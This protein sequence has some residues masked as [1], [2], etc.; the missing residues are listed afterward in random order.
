MLWLCDEHSRS[1]S[2]LRVSS[3]SLTSL[4]ST[5]LPK[6]PR[7]RDSYPII[8]YPRTAH[9]EVLRLEVHAPC[10]LGTMNLKCHGHL[11]QVAL[12]TDLPPSPGPG[13][14]Q[15][16]EFNFASNFLFHW[17]AVCLT[18]FW[19]LPFNWSNLKSPSL[20]KDSPVRMHIVPIS[21]GCVSTLRSSVY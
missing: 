12:K 10:I 20:S 3:G 7:D 19:L 14:C 17:K 8:G 6:M 9:E 18:A 2:C 15:Q 11:C 16:N 21:S 1:D 13:D 4:S 5:V